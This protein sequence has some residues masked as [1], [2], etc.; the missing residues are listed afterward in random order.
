VQNLGSFL[1]TDKHMDAAATNSPAKPG[2]PFRRLLKDSRKAVVF[3]LVCGVIITVVTGQPQ[4]FHKILVY[5]MCIG[6]IA[7]LI[8]NIARI[9]ILDPGRERKH[10]WLAFI[11]IVTAAAPASNYAGTMLADLLLG[12][13][14]QPL[15]AFASMRESGMVV[16]T[17]IAAY[18]AVLLFRNQER[19][20]RMQAQAESEK[21]RAETI[22]RQAMQAQLQLLQ[23]QVEPHMLFNTLANVQ[24]LIAID[25]ERATH[26]LDQLI[27]Y[28][29]ATLTSSRAEAT[30]L[31]HEFALIEAYLGLMSVRMGP[32]L[33]Y[34]LDLPEAL[35]AQKIPPMLLQPLVE[36]AIIHGLEPAVDGGEVAVTAAWHGGALELTVR[37]TGLG[38]GTAVARPGTRLGV[39]NTRE[40]LQGLYGG[41]ARLDL[42][43]AQPKGTVAR[44]TLPL[45]LP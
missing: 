28:L 39:A 30:T 44:L 9:A 10:G 43:P 36:N 24:G 2:F 15:R 19:M 31:E 17:L 38:L 20:M 35:R 21:A 26:M 5:S 16:F 3:N 6:T 25:P 12:D 1:Q 27:Q 13:S 41:L 22:A 33:A 29:R 11:A 7:F 45:E 4:K 32:R 40:R 18:G 42:E 37:D 14:P 23:A 8:I 34:R